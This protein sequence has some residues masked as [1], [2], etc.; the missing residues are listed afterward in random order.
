MVRRPQICGRREFSEMTDILSEEGVA[1]QAF[2]ALLQTGD[3]DLLGDEPLQIDGVPTWCMMSPGEIY[4]AVSPLNQSR[5]KALT[6]MKIG[7]VMNK[8]LKLLAEKKIIVFSPGNLL[9]SKTKPL[10]AQ[11]RQ[12]ISE[13]SE[14]GTA[15][16]RSML[17]A[18]SAINFGNQH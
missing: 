12:A 8:I 6:A 18:E 5:S 4:Y 13:M 15:L 3:F 14:A 11:Q 1:N 2:E 16:L 10:A 7:V 17:S 9:L